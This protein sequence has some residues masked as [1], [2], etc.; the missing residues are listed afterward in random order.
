[1][2]ES[3]Q[4]LDAIDR[5]LRSLPQRHLRNTAAS[6]PSIS[7]QLVLVAIAPFLMCTQL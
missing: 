6:T 7:C 2:P 5:K 4:V 3:T 1:M